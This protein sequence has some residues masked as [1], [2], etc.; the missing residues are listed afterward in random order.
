MQVFDRL[1]RIGP[2]RLETVHLGLVLDKHRSSLHLACRRARELAEAALH[3]V[4]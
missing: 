2:L 3:V 1:L 4:R